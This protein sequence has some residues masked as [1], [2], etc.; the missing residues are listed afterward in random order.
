MT[1]Q[2]ELLQI[3]RSKTLIKR[4]IQGAAIAFILICIFLT[5]SLSGDISFN[6]WIFL[7]VFAVTIAGAFGGMF[8]CFMGMWRSQGGLK[9]LLANV[10]SG[11]VFL[12]LCYI[13]LILALNAIGLWH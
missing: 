8:Y 11:L 5:V 4:A 12:V 2:N 9:K 13:S 6:P 7:P 1:W 10:V 3:L